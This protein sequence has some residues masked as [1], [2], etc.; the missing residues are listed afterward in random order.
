[1]IKPKDGRE[2]VRGK[3][4]KRDKY[5]CRRC[6]FRRTPQMVSKFNKDIQGLKG[7]IKQLDVHHKNGLCGKMSRGYDSIKTIKLLITL[8]HK[9]HYNRHDRSKKFLKKNR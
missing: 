6:G 5:T 9:C 2:Y 7:R 8:C 3:V 4:R 1:M